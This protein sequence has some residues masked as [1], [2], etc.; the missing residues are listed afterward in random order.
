[1]IGVLGFPA[2]FAAC[3]LLPLLATPVV[4]AEPTLK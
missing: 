1:L 2:A 4:P 3:A